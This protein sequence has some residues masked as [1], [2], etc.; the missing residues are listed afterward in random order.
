MQREPQD[1]QKGRDGRL[2]H[3]QFKTLKGYESGREITSAMEDYLEMIFRLS[4][5]HGPVRIK[6]LAERLS[7]LP[8]SASKMAAVLREHGLVDFERYGNVLLTGEGKVL[9]AYLIERHRAVHGLLCLING[10]DNELEETEKIEHYLSV[11]TVK[12][13]E[14]LLE[15]HKNP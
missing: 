2:D 15:A 7:V 3:E 1:R 12:N 4:E 5:E 14:R 13:I 6:T 9:G 8:S 11:R 10:S